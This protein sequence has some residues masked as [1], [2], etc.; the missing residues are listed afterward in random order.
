MPVHELLAKPILIKLMIECEALPKRYDGGKFYEEKPG[1]Y[2]NEYHFYTDGEKWFLNRTYYH[3]G[4]YNNG[5][6][7]YPVNIE[8]KGGKMINDCI[9][10]FT[11]D[12]ITEI[13]ISEIQEISNKNVN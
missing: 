10:D 8:I 4:N 3:E 2:W 1:L 12:E 5:F 13:I 9:K 7:C 6:T 11:Y